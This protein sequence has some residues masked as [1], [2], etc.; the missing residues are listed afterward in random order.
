MKPHKWQKEIIAWA[1]GAV[2]QYQNNSTNGRWT[3]FIVG[4]SWVK[5]TEYRASIAEVEGKPVFVGDVLYGDKGGVFTAT[6]NLNFDPNK[7]ETLSWNPPKTITITVTIPMP[8]VVETK[9]SD[10]W[11]EISFNDNADRQVFISAVKEA[12]K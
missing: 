11:A 6:L 1:N 10:G 3:D 12:M 2:I 5:D 4:P 8:R 9:M 7:G